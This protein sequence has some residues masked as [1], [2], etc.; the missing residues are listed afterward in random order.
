MAKLGLI[1]ICVFLMVQVSI[2]V[3]ILCNAKE[4]CKD[5]STKRIVKF[6]NT[7][8]KIKPIKHKQTSTADSLVS[9]QICFL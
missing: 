7:G 1:F 3:F 6:Y 8:E 9:S 4:Y 5:V 2:I